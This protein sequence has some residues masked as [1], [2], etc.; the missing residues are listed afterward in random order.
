MKKR[1]LSLF[2]ALILCLSL[3]PMSALAV[4]ISWPEINGT[5]SIDNVD[6]TYKGDFTSL[7]LD[8]TSSKYSGSCIFKAGNGYVLCNKDT[9][10]VILHNAEI[11][12]SY[13]LEVPSGAEVTVEGNNT[14]RAT[15]SY[16]LV[17]YTGGISVKGD[18]SLS[19]MTD[20]TG[21]F[22]YALNAG[23]G[24]VSVDITGAFKSGGIGAQS[25][26][27]TVKSSDAVTI[28]GL[29]NA[30][31]NIAVEAGTNLSITNSA[32]MAIKAGG[33]G[34]VSLTAKGGNITVSGGNNYNNNAINAGS[35]AITLDASGEI[36]VADYN[37]YPGVNGNSLNISG[38]IP[39]GSTLHSSCG[40]IVPE[41]K[42]LV[43]NG[44][45]FSN[46]GT[47]TVAGTLICGTGSEIKNGN[48]TITP[49]ATGAGTIQSAPVS[50]AKLD[51][52]F[53]QPTSVT[54]YS[55]TGGG[56]AKW[57]PGNGTANKLTLN[58]VTM[59]GES[60][61][62]GVPA[63]TE[64]I[65]IGTNKITATSA[66]ALCA[67]NGTLKII[68]DGSLEVYA[69]APNITDYAIGTNIGG[70]IDI[71]I[72]G[73]LTVNG[74]IRAN[75]GTLSLQSGDAISV[76]GSMYGKQKI[77]AIA[78][79]SLSITNTSNT[80]VFA[81]S[82]NEV[83]LA[84]QDGNLTV[85]GAGTNYAYGIDG[86]Y[87]KTALKLHASGNVSVTGTKYSVQGKT[88]ELS[89]T[90]PEGSTLTADFTDSMTIPA[91]KTLINNGTIRLDKYPASVTVFGTLTNNGSIVD[92]KGAPIRPTVNDGGVIT[93]QVAM[94]FTG[95]DTNDTG[96][97]YSWDYASKT[98]TL[99]NYKMTEPRNDSAIILPDN[100]K[101][102]LSG[103][104]TL[105]SKNGALIDANGTLEISGTGSLTGSA[106]GEAALN[107][108]G[109]LTI[110]DCKLD[111]TNPSHEKTVICT[112]GNALTITGSADVSLH[113]EQSF[114][115]GIK[116]GDGG[117]L[118]L[119]S[120]AKLTVSGETGI[121]VGVGNN[122]QKVAT[123]KIAGMLDVSN[124]ANL[125]ANLLRVTLNMEGSSI[126]ASTEK[127]GGIYLYQN[128]AG[129]L[130][131]QTNIKAF[132]GN[133]KV[134]S[135][136][137]STV[138]YYKVQKD[139]TLGLYAK[140]STV[141]FT[142]EQKSGKA[143]S[144]WMAT[145]VTLDKPSNAEISFTMPG[146]DVT[147]TTAYTTLVNKVSLDKTELAL[148]VGDKQTLKATILPSDASNKAISWSSDNPSVAKV[149]EN[150]NITAV[151]AGTA[152]ITVKTVNGEKTAACAVTVTAKSSGGSSSG[153]SSSPSYPVTT[154][155]KT[156]NGTVT[157]SPRSAE[158]GDSVTITV[159][160]DSGYQLDDLTVT[161][162]NGKEVKLTDKGNGKYTFTM[163][164]SKVE[165]NATFVK[166]VET[167]PFSDVATSA[168]YYEAVKWAQEKG[169]TGGTG[170]GLFGPNQPCTRGQIVTFLWRAAG[171]PEPKNM[172]S[173]TDVPADSYYAKAVAWAV[174]NGITGGTGGGKFSPDAT[175]TRE[176]AVAFLYRASGSPAVSGGSV[177]NDV[178]AN[179]YYADA[180]AWA[181][182]NGVTGGIGNGKFGTGSDCTRAQIV[183]FLYRT[184]QGK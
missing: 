118:T 80:A 86:D 98:L 5:V 134:T 160:P 161:D 125:G 73:A 87:S 22:A 150:G 157:V 93:G 17:C 151:A 96:E 133:F 158:K 21:L 72:T 178:A 24:N 88:L 52:R 138:N 10:R 40:V 129:T 76:T 32:N 147:L 149:D 95:K 33:S 108:Q 46:S 34:T 176:Q 44:T 148:T 39:E 13:A 82:C 6:Y 163:P 117:N 70:N 97:G 75:D 35:S 26:T 119:D 62:V 111:L 168:Y 94:D 115:F 109:A 3:L 142:A 53:D 164:A 127:D 180:V 177:F 1:V 38:T 7:S 92:D 79:K 106:G 47:V 146:S 171:S 169:I 114:G 48:G 182:K 60:Y 58:G 9:K 173:F 141:T 51:F 68:G 139:N 102:V 165:I 159:K 152:N 8:L 179:A 174:E 45:L 153:G 14:L 116:T 91:G 128:A 66:N 43:N 71:D 170:N 27:I 65:L 11:T 20:D 25:G 103:E 74:N 122:S 132:V 156:E 175:C 172:S 140:D 123:V 23:S 61:V 120:N 99:T 84:A 145:G 4:E 63:N 130:T 135:P 181:E 107:A 166:E 162:K 131:G 112:N 143:F 2:M 56:T 41:G 64:I 67:Q 83:S 59:T 31:S 183:T 121:L 124:C 110:T 100:A 42:T 184:Y 36:R 167:S 54:E 69:P 15:S 136:N 104:N 101:L 81:S 55:I 57:E 49:T 30:G 105:Y 126:T 137:A 77:T 155:G 18:G 12:A 19:A 144:T 85:S 50:V 37:G 90:I 154:P 29:V 16:A 89:G 113:T 28:T 78:G